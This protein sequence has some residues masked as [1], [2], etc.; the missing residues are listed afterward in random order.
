MSEEL[1]QFQASIQEILDKTGKLNAHNS[2]SSWGSSPDKESVWN[3][4]AN[5]TNTK[6]QEIPGFLKSYQSMKK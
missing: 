6:H 5:Q 3:T 4:L 1:E 2:R